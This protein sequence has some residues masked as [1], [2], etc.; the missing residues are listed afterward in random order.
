MGKTK[1]T[2]W[3]P[4][5]ALKLALCALFYPNWAMSANHCFNGKKMPQIILESFRFPPNLFM[6]LVF[7]SYY[8]C[9]SLVPIAILIFSQ[10][11]QKAIKECPVWFHG[12]E[13]QWQAQVHIGTLVHPKKYKE[14][15]KLGKKSTTTKELKLLL[16][17]W[18]TCL[19]HWG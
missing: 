8:F 16:L 2:I 4:F 12:Y 18:F 17:S 5:P 9:S 1:I 11:V 19:V 10:Q 13:T 14:A 6:L 15:S 7:F 3:P